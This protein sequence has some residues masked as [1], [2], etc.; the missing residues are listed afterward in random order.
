MR[1][2]NLD[3]HSTC[4]FRFGRL[5]HTTTNPKRERLAVRRLMTGRHQQTCT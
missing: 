1:K 4:P 2:A 5:P 3:P